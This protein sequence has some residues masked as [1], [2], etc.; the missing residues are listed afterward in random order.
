MDPPPLD[1]STE[2]F[3]LPGSCGCNECPTGGLAAPSG[4]PNLVSIQTNSPSN[5]LSRYV[6]AARARARVHPCA[7]ARLWGAAW[8][9]RQGVQ[10][11][12]AA[13]PLRQRS[14]PCPFEW[15]ATGV[16]QPQR[17]GVIGAG[18]VTL[19]GKVSRT[20]AWAML[21]LGSGCTHPQTSRRSPAP[22]LA[23]PRQSAPI[24]TTKPP[25]AHMPP[26]THTCLRPP[27]LLPCRP[28]RRT[29]LAGW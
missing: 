9:S 10:T 6:P 16:R 11:S 20:S 25:H 13:L 4:C 24:L 17:V 2:H 23:A 7:S 12:G 8:A 22:P 29:T 5:Q 28:W 1:A 21:C 3:G 18:V 14:S 15:Q 26:P 27:D 19:W